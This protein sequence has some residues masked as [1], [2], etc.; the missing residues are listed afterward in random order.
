MSRP[1]QPSKRLDEITPALHAYCHSLSEAFH[2]PAE[3]LFQVAYE[4]ALRKEPTFD[5][6]RGVTF[7]TY[8][9]RAVTGAVL[10]YALKNRPLSD[11]REWELLFDAAASQVERVTE[12]VNVMYDSEERLYERAGDMRSGMATGMGAAVA[13]E[14]WVHGGGGGGVGGAGEDPEA[15][16]VRAAERRKVL[17]A[18]EKAIGKLGEGDRELVRRVGLAGEDLT[19]A[20]RGMPEWRERPYITA[21]KHYGRVL[22]RIGEWMWLDDGVTAEAVAAVEGG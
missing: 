1:R 5:P 10:R 3:E 9:W 18:L 20:L 21:W 16:L 19:V 12:P 6:T 13:G 8:V 15:A 17:G 14:S 4:E 22:E 11:V 2:E 7:L